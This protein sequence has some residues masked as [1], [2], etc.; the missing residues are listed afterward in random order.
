MDCLGWS[1]NCLALDALP[2]FEVHAIPGFSS[3]RAG[4]TW[5]FDVRHER[6]RITMAVSLLLNHEDSRA[7]VIIGEVE[8]DLSVAAQRLM[9]DVDS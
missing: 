4:R 5:A 3:S 9:K 2:P 6:Q 7:E 8:L 1:S